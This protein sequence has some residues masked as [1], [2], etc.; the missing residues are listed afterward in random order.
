VVRRFKYASDPE[1]YTS[2][3]VATGRASLAGQVKDRLQTK[4]D[5]RIDARSSV[6]ISGFKYRANDVRC[7]SS[8]YS[9]RRDQSGLNGCCTAMWKANRKT[10]TLSHFLDNLFPKTEISYTQNASSGD[11]I[12]RR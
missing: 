8:S 1:S 6:I 11:K 9:N 5:T 3:S 10:T 12:I 4:R 7:V 2:G